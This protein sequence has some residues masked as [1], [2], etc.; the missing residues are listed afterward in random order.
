MARYLATLLIPEE[1]HQGRFF[2]D[3]SR[4]LLYAVVLAL[5]DRAGTAWT[6]R[7]LISALE[8]PATIKAVTRNTPRAFAIAKSIVNDEKHSSAVL[9]TLTTRTGPFE[10]V[11]A[12]W[13]TSRNKRVFSIKEFLSKPGVLI[14]GNDEVL[15]DSLWPIN[16]LLLKALTHEILRR[17]GPTTRLP[18]HWFVLDEFRWMEKV[19]CIH[20]LLN[21]GRSKGASVL[22]GIQSLEG[23]I[24][25][26]KEPVANDILSQ[27]ANKTFLRAGGPKTAEWAE[28]F[29][30][31]VRHT[32][33]VYSETSGKHP[34]SSVNHALQEHALF[35]DS[36]FLNLPFPTPG[37]DYVAINDVPALNCTLITK[38][39]FNE[40]LSWTAKPPHS[41][42]V[43]QI[44]NIG[45]LAAKLSAEEPDAVSKFVISRFSPEAKNALSAFNGKAPDAMRRLL[46]KEL[47][48][49]IASE[50][51][52]DSRAFEGV[53][54]SARTNEILGASEHEFQTRALNQS[55]LVDAFPKELTLEP[56]PAIILRS[57]VSEQT[58]KPWTKTEKAKFCS[59][60]NKTADDSVQKVSAPTAEPTHYP[61]RQPVDRPDPPL[62]LD[63]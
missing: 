60:K 23:M 36:T 47:N 7:D 1:K 38:R 50:S 52:L 5:N 29:F 58:L 14:L 17:P 21:R 16:A 43:G 61:P 12:L 55:L 49:I 27:C 57:T 62:P 44:L 31:K 33:N 32:I 18:R 28:K 2:T 48:Q 6:F 30:G 63:F 54:L 15:K 46:V 20:D 26:Y 10:Q 35:L 13:S 8:S 25:V 11:A 45:S 4:E 22:I 34:S 56:V 3:A 24:E 59:P 41:F 42:S 40:V 51:V 53:S 39:P 19:E 37:S 9:S